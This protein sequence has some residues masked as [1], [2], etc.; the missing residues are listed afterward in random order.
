MAGALEPGGCSELGC[1]RQASDR[2]EV[3]H[4]LVSLGDGME[5]SIPAI[6]RSF[7]LFFWRCKPKETV[8]G[9]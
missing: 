4:V 9:N 8:Q 3:A 7:P 2:G 5:D 6:P 1:A